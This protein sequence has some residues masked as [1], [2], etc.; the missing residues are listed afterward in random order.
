MTNR[1]PQ[2]GDVYRDEDGHLCLYVRTEKRP[3]RSIETGAEPDEPEHLFVVAMPEI[4]HFSTR[5][6]RAGQPLPETLELAVN[7][8]AEKR[9][10]ELEDEVR[11][12]RAERHA[13]VAAMKAAVA[14]VPVPVANNLRRIYREQ[15]GRVLTREAA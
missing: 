4:R 1:A 14:S 2:T 15:K 5:W 3:G 10:E 6:L 12:L 11:E 13:L 9:I 8:G 7:A